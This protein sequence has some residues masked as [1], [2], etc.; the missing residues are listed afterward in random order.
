[1]KKLI[2]ILAAALVIV[3]LGVSCTKDNPTNTSGGGQSSGGGSAT[4]S[5]AGTT[6]STAEQAGFGTLTLTFTANDCTLKRTNGSNSESC[7]Y[8]YTFSGNTVKTKVKLSVWNGGE[9]QEATG[10]VSGNGMNFKLS[11]NGSNYLFSKK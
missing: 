9:E 11:K 4:S 5:I 7:T 10:T 6:W 8:P 1:M 2:S 3:S